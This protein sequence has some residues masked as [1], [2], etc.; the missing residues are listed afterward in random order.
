M[1]QIREQKR[2]EKK[3][4]RGVKKREREREREGGGGS[5]SR[6][7]VGYAAILAWCQG[8]S[9]ILE[10]PGNVHHETLMDSMSLSL[11]CMKFMY[12]ELLSD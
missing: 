8:M 5:C 12:P 9:V 1:R 10:V 4:R 3:K 6:Q 11:R 2:S 7:D